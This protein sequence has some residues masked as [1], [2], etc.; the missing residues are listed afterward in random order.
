MP[1]QD[2]TILVVEEEYLIALEI[3]SILEGAEIGRIEI[4]K[5]LE[6]FEVSSSGGEYAAA[7]IELKTYGEKPHE[8]VDRLQ[9]AG[10]PIIFGTAF[11]DYM[12]GVPGYPDAPV[13][14]KPY[15]TEQILKAVRSAIDQVE[16]ETASRPINAAASA[17]AEGIACKPS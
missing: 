10:I 9:A 2:T 11:D 17:E 15:A 7:I 8:T 13:I 3:E 6:E 1:L 16:T 5:S 12:E 4:I 14:L